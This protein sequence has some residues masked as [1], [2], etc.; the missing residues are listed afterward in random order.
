MDVS[1]PR[2]IL[3]SLY[4]FLNC[5]VPVLVQYL[6]WL[7]AYTVK[8]RIFPLA[9]LGLPQ[10][11]IDPQC[12]LQAIS[13]SACLHVGQ[14]IWLLASL[15]LLCNSLVVIVELLSVICILPPP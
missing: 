14:S 13:I 2:E 8:C 11:V 15:S 7:C 4:F 3:F 1:L 5:T 12:R 6:C 9:A 10:L